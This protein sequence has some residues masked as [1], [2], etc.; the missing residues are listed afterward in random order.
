MPAMHRDIKDVEGYLAPVC[1]ELSAGERCSRNGR[2]AERLCYTSAQ[3]WHP[4]RWQ[5]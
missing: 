5:L 4:D 2:G 1:L 3:T